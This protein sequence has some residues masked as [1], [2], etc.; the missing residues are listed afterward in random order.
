[1]LAGSRT[2]ADELFWAINAAVKSWDRA[3]GQTDEIDITNFK[4][5]LEWAA[6]IRKRDLMDRHTRLNVGLN[7]EEFLQRGKNVLS[8]GHYLEVWTDLRRINL[9]AEL[10]VATFG[11]DEPVIMRIAA[12]AHVYWEDHFSTIGTGGPIAEAFLVQRDYDDDMPLSECLVRVMEAKIAAEK[13]RDVGPTTVL[14]VMVLEDSGPKRYILTDEAFDPYDRAIRSH[15]EKLPK[16]KFGG[17]VLE[18]V[19]DTDGE[20]EEVQ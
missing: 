9:G 7:F 20:P 14:E 10:I 4:K 13:N 3:A 16:V 11:Q 12:D 15:L 8:E 17:T 2:A 6:Q 5:S 1:L 18:L 19:T